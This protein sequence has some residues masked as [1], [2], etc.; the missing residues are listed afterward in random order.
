MHG[1]AGDPG[2]L[3]LLSPDGFYK[4][5]WCFV[6]TNA[7]DA[8]V[9]N[10]SYST[11]TQWYPRTTESITRPSQ[12]FLFFAMRRKTCALWKGNSCVSFTGFSFH[13]GC[14]VYS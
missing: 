2:F 14:S 3:T 5:K 9:Y 6:F 11:V 4:H 12:Y 7:N 10:Q 8:D 13:R 1:Q